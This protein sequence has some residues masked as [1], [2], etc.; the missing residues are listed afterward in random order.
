MSV[1]IGGCV[2]REIYEED[3]TTN[4]MKRCPKGMATHTPQRQRGEGSHAGGRAQSRVGSRP[5][6]QRAR[7]TCRQCDR[8]RDRVAR[9]EPSPSRLLPPR[10]PHRCGALHADA[11]P[12]SSPSPFFTSQ[13]TPKLGTHQ[14]VDKLWRSFPPLVFGDF[15]VVLGKIGRF[16]S[17]ESRT[18]VWGGLWT[19]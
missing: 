10:P 7:V 15:V 16:I 3:I 4:H 5:D 1:W 11:S 2:I 17:E 8:C 6:C 9:S 19:F 13:C 14:I 18:C 12:L